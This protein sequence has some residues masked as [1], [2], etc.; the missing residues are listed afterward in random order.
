[1]PQLGLSFP[2]VH[3][4]FVGRSNLA[5]TVLKINCQCPVNSGEG[6]VN[7]VLFSVACFHKELIGLNLEL[8]QPTGLLK[9]YK[10]EEVDH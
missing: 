1:M 3:E 4:A 8:H 9:E 2:Y 5:S 7:S 10:Q 6:T